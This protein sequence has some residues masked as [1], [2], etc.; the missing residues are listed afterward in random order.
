MHTYEMICVIGKKKGKMSLLIQIWYR[1]DIYPIISV[2][3]LHGGGV[4]PIAPL[5]TQMTSYHR[6]APHWRGAEILAP[7]RQPWLSTQRSL[8]RFRSLMVWLVDELNNSPLYQQQVTK[9][10]NHAGPLKSLLLVFNVVSVFHLSPPRLR[11]VTLSQTIEM[12]FGEVKTLCS[13]RILIWFTAQFPADM[14]WHSF[15]WS[16]GL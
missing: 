7:H 14:C 13:C 3:S 15:Y 12:Q 16:I 10:Y 9:S 11:P 8:F 4:S 1:Y 6:D 5:I 2:R